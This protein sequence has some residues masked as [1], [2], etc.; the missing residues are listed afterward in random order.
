VVYKV[1]AD[2]A[3]VPE[4]RDLEAFEQIRPDAAEL[5]DL[6][7]VNPPSWQDDLG[8]LD[9]R[10]PDPD[11]AYITVDEELQIRPVLDGIKGGLAC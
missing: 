4:Q 11:P 6:R 8:P 1:G 5:E 10:V 3:Q 7:R 9:L 2:A